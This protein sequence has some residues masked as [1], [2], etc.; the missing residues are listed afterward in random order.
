MTKTSA[1]LEKLNAKIPPGY[2]KLGKMCLVACGA[3]A[4]GKSYFVVDLI[5]KYQKSVSLTICLSPTI[6]LDSMY[7]E[8]KKLPNL[9]FSETVNNDVLS[10]IISIQKERFK[11]DKTA[12]LLLVLD[13]SGGDLRRKA[14]R[15]Q[16]SKIWTTGRHLGIMLCV[17]VQSLSHLES[18][19]IQNTSQW[20]LFGMPARNLKKLSVDLATSFMDEK[21]L[22]DYIGDNTKKR[23]SYVY[24]DFLADEHEMFRTSIDL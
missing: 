23:Y 19:S 3:R 11:E 20:V 5:K 12:Y 15:E 22:Y 9:M 16:I 2:P 14:L 18:I 6:H 7:D 8:V 17:C 1:K 4:S 21:E 13:D 10:Q 24:I